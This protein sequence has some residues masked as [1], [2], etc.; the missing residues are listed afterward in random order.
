MMNLFLVTVFIFLLYVTWERTWQPTPVLLPGKSHGWR[1]LVAY[2]AWGCE[3]SDMTERLHF[4][5]SF[6]CIGAGNINP[7]QYSCL[8]NP[9]DRGA[10][11]THI[12]N[13]SYF[14]SNDTQ[15]FLSIVKYEPNVHQGLVLLKTTT[16]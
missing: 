8:E 16:L 15:Q 1:I 9:R 10:W 5:F 12:E 14:T 7:L 11:W 13:W 4:H 6:S 3:E 2:S